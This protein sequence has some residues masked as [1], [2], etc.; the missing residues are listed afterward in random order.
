[1]TRHVAA[2]R[3]RSNQ[4]KPSAFASVCLYLSSS[5]LFTHTHAHIHSESHALTLQRL[6]NSSMG[7]PV[8]MVCAGC[9]AVGSADTGVHFSAAECFTKPMVAAPQVRR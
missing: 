1:M 9:Q 5:R 3:R 4:S 2:R 7:C 8:P 6:L